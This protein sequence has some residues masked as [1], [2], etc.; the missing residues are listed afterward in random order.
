MPEVSVVIPCFN[1]EKTIRQLLDAIYAQ[2]YPRDN[3]EVIIA[4]G[5]S[6]DQ[7]L[8]EIQSFKADCRDLDVRVVNNPKRTI[9]AGVNVGISQA[10]GEFIVRLD[11]HSIP[12]P[13]YVARSVEGLRKELGANVG[14]VW[15]IQPGEPTWIGRSIAAAASHPLGVGDALYRYTNQPCEVDTVPFGAFR[16]QMIDKIGWYDETLLTNEDYEFNTRIRQAGG[17]IWLDPAIRSKYFARPNLPALARQYWRYGYWKFRMLRR[18]PGTVRMR[19]ALPPLFV[20]S[21][22]GLTVVALVWSPGAWFLLTEVVLYLLIL[23]LASIPIARREQNGLMVIGIPLAI[24][25][26]HISWGTGFI[27]SGLKS[28]ISGSQRVKG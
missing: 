27:V 14:G 26:M 16:K 19:Q 7:T 2:T 20:A 4:D 28:L 5:G 1:E 25:V 10:K 23:G 17:K 8:L 12:N 3:L 24:I 13:D 21:L 11:A 6:T 15:E 22:F 18:Y 9:P